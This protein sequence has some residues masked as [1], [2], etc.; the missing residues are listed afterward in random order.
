MYPGLS[1]VHLVTF[2]LEGKL[3]LHTYLLY[4]N[5]AISAYGPI[6]DSSVNKRFL[7]HLWSIDRVGLTWNGLIDDGLNNSHA[8]VAPHLLCWW[9]I[10]SLPKNLFVTIVAT[11]LQNITAQILV[12][13]LP[14]KSNTPV[15]RKHWMAILCLSNRHAIIVCLTQSSSF[16]VKC[17]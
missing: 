17:V 3:V 6:C 2:K 12:C 5:F 1:L 4:A 7:F 13:T 14:R 16:I 11:Y 10:S 15:L 8:H 9:L